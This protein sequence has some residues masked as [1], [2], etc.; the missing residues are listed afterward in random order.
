MLQQ[1]KSWMLVGGLIIL[2]PCLAKAD[3]TANILG[4]VTDPS[5][6]VIAGVQVTATNTGTNAQ[7]KATS[8]SKGEYRFLALPVGVY[9]VQATYSGFQTFTEKDVVLTV[10]EQHRVDITMQVGATSQEVSVTAN[11]GEIETTSTQLG[12]VIEEKQILQLPL[13]GRSYLD[14][15]SLQSGVAPAGTRGEGPGTISVNGQ[16]ENSNGF[17]VNGGDVSN[18]GNFQAGIQPNLDSIEEFRLITNSF[19]AEYGRFSGALTNAITKSG[20]NRIHGSAFEFLRNNAM[21]SRGFFDGDIGT[22]KRNQFGYAVGGP[23]IKDKLF[24]FTDYQGTREINGGTASNVQVLT[25]D[26]RAGNIGVDN[27]AG[28]VNGPAWAAILAQRTGTTVTD[29]EAY[30][31]VF[32]TG[33]IPQSVW[34]AAAKGTIGFIPT[35]NVQGQYYASAAYPTRTVDNMFGQKVDFINRLTGNWSIYYYYQGTNT[36][37]ALAGASWPGFAAVT[38]VKNQQVT[39]S[40]TRTINPSTVNEFRFSFTRLPVQTVPTG[41]AAPSL[42]SMGFVTG[43]GTDGINQSGPT[44]YLGVPTIS[45]NEFGFGTVAPSIA[46]QNTFQ[47][48]DSLSKIIGR[49]TLKFGADYRYYQMNQRNAGA[50]VGQF[51]FD[52]SET[53]SDVAD[54]LLGSP[55]NYTQSSLQLLDSRS[56]YGAAFAQDSIRLRTNLTINL[57]LR[58]EFSQPWYDTQNKIVALVPG[59]QSVEY[60]TAPKGLVY[61]GDP[62]VPRTLA[63]TRYDN[64]APRIG[65]AYSPNHSDGF[66][67]K[68]LGGPGKTSIRLAGGEFFTAIQDQTL[69]WILGTVP[70]G[71]YWG[72]AAPPLFESPFTTRSTGQSQGH[73]FPFVIPAPG[74]AAAKN[75]DFSY[76]Y[77]LSST[78]GYATDNALPYGIDYNLTIQRQLSKSMFLSV[79]YVGT[80]GRKLI[81][82]Q[83][84]NPGDPNLCLQLRAEG[85]TPTCGPRQEDNTFTLPNGTQVHGTRG[86]FGPAFSTSFYEGDWANSDY[87]SL[88]A[89]L[90]KRAGRS[91]FLAAYTFAK[92]IDNGSYFNDRLNYF[93]HSLSRALSNF[94]VTH[95]FVV[96]YFYTVP[97]DRA[98]ASLPKRLVEGWSVAGITRFATGFPVSL[99]EGDDRALRGTS[100]IDM[101]NVVGPLDITGNPRTSANHTWFSKSAFA[102]ESLGVV[103][104]ADPRFF[105]GP[106][107][108][109]WTLGLHKDTRL[110]E[111]MNLQIRFES[112]NTF[113]HAQ[114]ANPSGSFTS[115]QFGNITSIGAVGPRIMQVAA[116][117]TF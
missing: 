110:A 112:F 108:N 43:A 66:L 53:G 16:R 68:L 44:G 74:S 26:Q 89:S 69:Y 46:N 116:K 64:F 24:W 75:F 73:P 9:V 34:S 37:N 23:A 105:Y 18:V 41:A 56:K 72:S 82:I 62:G 58:W 77:P 99:F 21:D 50:P 103:G 94:D 92:G 35:A 12:L 60:P 17:L 55:A 29:G 11:A 65:I 39:L 86:P 5:G 111:G 42:A 57:G 31:Q 106:G 19:D 45:T 30:S 52:G 47:V 81:G 8:D 96:S 32:P 76:Y 40:N 113:N 54:F 59:E 27:L 22:L 109:N 102:P 33:I 85:A 13:D 90:E 100:G 67:G 7:A 88:Q 61:P 70:F 78:L 28:T 51:S 25:A 1:W 79:G 15:L 48:Q 87:N 83:E 20:A 98:F 117:I 97:F 114:F 63:P 4:V 2:G 10:N 84:A 95:N 14:L 3:V 93:D 91:T 71:E 101:P 80:L 38:Q 49:H 104:D 6:A 115:G 36:N 107:I